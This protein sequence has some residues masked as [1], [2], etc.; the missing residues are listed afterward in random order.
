MDIQCL[1]TGSSGNCYI[2]EQE[3]YKYL[4]DCGIELRRIIANINLNELDFAFI[5]HE[6]K[7]HSL[8]LDNLVKRGV[9]CLEGRFT[10]DFEKN[11][12]IGSKSTQ[13]RLYTFPI[14]HGECRNAGLIVQT[15]NE[16]LLYVT[17]FS[18]CRYNLKQFKFT[19]IMVECNYDESYMSK[20]NLDYKHLRQI[21]THMGFDGLKTFIDKA[22]DLEPIQEILLIHASS[23]G[24]LIDRKILLMKAKLEWSN[25]KVGICLQK[26]GIDYG[27]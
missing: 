21:N 5:S 24:Q 1:A 10:Q 22:I 27:G 3:G 16:C 6:H 23:E 15:P 12:F 19:K 26:G 25:K 4:L 9:R 7:D 8:S 18:L 14:E 20:V 2:V 11:I 17:D 13:I